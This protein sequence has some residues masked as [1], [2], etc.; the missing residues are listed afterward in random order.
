MHRRKSTGGQID[1]GRTSDSN[2]IDVSARKTGGN[3]PAKIA[4]PNH[5]AS[6]GV[7]SIDIVRFGNRNNHRSIWAPLDVK[8]LG[9][10]VA[11]DRT[12]EV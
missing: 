5:G 7:E 11:G 12:S 3:G 10:N 6:G 9:V 1:H 4:Y 2:R 8:W